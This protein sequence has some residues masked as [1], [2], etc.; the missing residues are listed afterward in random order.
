MREPELITFESV[1]SSEK[2]YQL[3]IPYSFIEDCKSFKYWKF[4]ITFW[5]LKCLWIKK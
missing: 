5:M 2:I 3:R 4:K 1:D